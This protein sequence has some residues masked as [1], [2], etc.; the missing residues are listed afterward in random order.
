M[1]EIF[2]SKILVLKNVYG[3]MEIWRIINAV[4]L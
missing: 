4:L 1:D 2:V 3:I